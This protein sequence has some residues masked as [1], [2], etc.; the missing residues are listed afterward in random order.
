MYGFP[1]ED[2]QRLKLTAIDYF[3]SIPYYSFYSF[4]IPVG[5]LKFGFR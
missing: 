4:G 5:T 2:R 3:D 1:S